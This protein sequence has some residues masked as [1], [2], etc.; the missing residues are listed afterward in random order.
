MTLFRIFLVL[1]AAAFAAL[2]GWA[3][4]NDPQSLSEA[5]MAMFDAPWT[6]TAIA[7]LYI[8]F[9]IAATI[10]VLAEEKLWVGLAWGLPIFLA[11]NVVT[12][13]WLA[14]RFPSIAQRL[15]AR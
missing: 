14:I 15:R 9:F 13:I 8:G 2:L 7:D 12:L 4:L 5:F 10:I 1:L 3:Q 11:G 6:T